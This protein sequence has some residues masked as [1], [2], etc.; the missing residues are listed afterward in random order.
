MELERYHE[1]RMRT[2]VQIDPDSFLRITQ[3]G[4]PYAISDTTGPNRWEEAKEAYAKAIEIDP[5]H[6]AAR[7]GRAFDA[8][9]GF[10]SSSYLDGSVICGQRRWLR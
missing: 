2:S 8:M 4:R 6:E 7:E 3:G 9:A 10:S 5:T 1:A